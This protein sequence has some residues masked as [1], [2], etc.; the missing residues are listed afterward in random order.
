[1]AITIARHWIR[2]HRIDDKGAVDPT[3]SLREELLGLVV[4]S[5]VVVGDSDFRQDQHRIDRR[6]RLGS[7][8]LLGSL[9]LRDVDVDVAPVVVRAAVAR[10]VVH[11]HVSHH[12]SHVL[13]RR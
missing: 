12:V 7:Q 11:A 9:V 13:A 2:M 8:L 10:A 3:Q 6:H 4:E 5:E 1:M